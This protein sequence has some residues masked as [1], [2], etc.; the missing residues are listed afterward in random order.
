MKINK[1]KHLFFE[2][3]NKMD[4]SQPKVTKIR[5]DAL[6]HLPPRNK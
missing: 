1:G 6:Q 3:I 2:K 5:K 4:K